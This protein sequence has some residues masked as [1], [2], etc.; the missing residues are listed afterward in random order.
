MNF[1]AALVLLYVEDEALAWMI[2]LRIM[3]ID[4]WSK[5]YLYSTPK[6]FEMSDKVK[7][8]ISKELPI[9]NEV[10]KKYN[11]LLESLLASVFMTLFSNL[12]SLEHSSRI[13]DRFILGIT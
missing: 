8:Y 12:V 5:L 7:K 11:V 13:L 4:N 9:L 6:L 1:I 2:F 3:G 10:I